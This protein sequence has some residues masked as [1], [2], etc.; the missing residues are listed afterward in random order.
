MLI[1][2]V[3]YIYL[4]SY[5]LYKTIMAFQNLHKETGLQK[6]NNIFFFKTQSAIFHYEYMPVQHTISI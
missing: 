4:I 3:Y 5:H 6:K 1:F 2:T